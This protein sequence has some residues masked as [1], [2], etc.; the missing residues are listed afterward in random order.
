TLALL[1]AGARVAAV[2]IDG[3]LAGRLRTTVEERAA[4]AADRLTVVHQDAMTLTGPAD[5]TGP[6][7]GV[8]SAAP[9]GGGP[10]Q[11]R[12]A[13]AAG[14]AA[15]AGA[16]DR[17]VAN[18]PYNVSVPVLLR[19]LERFPSLASGVVMVQAEVGERLAASPGSK[20]YGA[21]SV[22]V[23]WYGVWRVRARIGRGVFWPVPNVD[24][25][26]VGF[27]R[28][29][30]PD[31]RAAAGAQEGGR[32][33]LRERVFALVDA[34]FGQ[35]RKMLRRT[36]APLY[37]GAMAAARALTAAGIDPALRGER[38]TVGDFIRLAAGSEER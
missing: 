9:T 32:G 14:E 27:E 11:A 10:V 30:P 3:R 19:V 22:K 21:P 29:P 37:G 24:S 13:A 16:P 20:T 31:G 26:L 23:A 28:T 34:A 35:R 4:G 15:R 6:G 38:L 2:E 17:L 33:L 18:L 25:V 12:G 36:L 8:A 5:V 1:E 7:D